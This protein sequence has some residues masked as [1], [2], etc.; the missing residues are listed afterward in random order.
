MAGIGADYDDHG[1]KPS[2][3]QEEFELGSKFCFFWKEYGVKKILGFWIVCAHKGFFLDW[4]VNVFESNEAFTCFNVKWKIR[5]C[6]KNS[7]SPNFWIK[8]VWGEV[9]TIFNFDVCKKQKDV[10]VDN[11]PNHRIVFASLYQLFSLSFFLFCF[12][13]WS[14][15]GTL[16]MISF[17]PPTGSGCLIR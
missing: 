16:F 12:N 15:E 3:R 7:I 9:G 1:A 6:L 17:P 2:C 11:F 10:F 13:F 8:E 4:I 14:L 5:H